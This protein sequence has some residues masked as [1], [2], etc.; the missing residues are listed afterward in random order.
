MVK[1]SLGYSLEY[2]KL[3]CTKH[4]NNIW[5]QTSHTP[6]FMLWRVVCCFVNGILTLSVWPCGCVRTFVYELSHCFHFRKNKINPFDIP[7]F[8]VLGCNSWWIV[9]IWQRA[10]SALKLH[11][12]TNK[13]FANS[14]QD[15]K[16]SYPF[17]TW[18]RACVNFFPAVFCSSKRYGLFLQALYITIDTHGSIS[19]YIVHAFISVMTAKFLSHTLLHHF[20]K[21]W[22]VFFTC[23]VVV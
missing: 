23:F 15:C 20:R 7:E 16:V 14:S 12:S 19:A 4:E 8:S 9:Q 3:R 11:F 22:V 5:T 13:W 1:I 18:R 2:G 21:S 6:C 10:L 17:Q